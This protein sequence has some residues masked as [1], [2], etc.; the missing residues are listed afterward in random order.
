MEKKI[1][2]IL[3]LIDLLSINSPLLLQ[4]VHVRRKIVKTVILLHKIK[5]NFTGSR[6]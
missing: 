5:R 1:K 6:N 3:I 2:I 4:L